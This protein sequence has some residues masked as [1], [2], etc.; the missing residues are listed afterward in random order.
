VRILGDV[1]WP[2]QEIDSS[3]PDFDNVLAG[4]IDSA[5]E[6]FG[7]RTQV[8]IWGGSSRDPIE[9]ARRV[10]AVTDERQA[11]VI[12]TEGG[13][14]SFQNG[15]NDAQLETILQLFRGGRL[16]AA[17][18]PG[19]GSD[20]LAQLR[21]WRVKGANV[22]TLHLDRSN[23]DED[24]RFVR[25][26]WDFRDIGG[27]LSNNEPK[28]PR[29]SVSQTTDVAR[30]CMA[31]AVGIINGL[32]AYVLHNG[33]GVT[34]RIDPAHD[35]PANLWEVPGI[36][37]LMTRLRLVDELLPLGVENWQK[38]TQH[39]GTERVG[40]HALL[41][42]AIWSDGADHGVSRNY[43]A[44]FGDFFVHLLLGVKRRVSLTALRR[45]TLEAIDVSSGEILAEG[46]GQT[47]DILTGR[48]D[49]ALGVVV[50]GRF[51]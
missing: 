24:W 43:G 47:L 46:T 36:D 40:P 4:F 2:G 48:D 45:V 20:A 11:R 41:A 5:Y 16:I 35:R 14:E 33:A 49:A 6:E 29:S 51:V 8:T 34:G 21:A 17:T 26:A 3:A 25:Q 28:G 31:R 19:P 27:L 18:C 7:L 23:G 50:R 13:N 32:G 10:R 37:E 22:G 44:V 39:G 42:D 1:G 30:L 12:F 15:P 38:T 9:A